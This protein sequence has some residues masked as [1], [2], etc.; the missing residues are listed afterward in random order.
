MFG[1]AGDSITVGNEAGVTS[2]LTELIAGSGDEVLNGAGA[3]SGLAFFGSADGA[4]NDTLT[5]G[6]GN[7]TLVAGT[8]NETL[9]G[10]AGSDLFVLNMQTDANG[11]ITIADFAGSS[12]DV[13]GF[14]RWLHARRYRERHRGRPGSGR[15]LRHHAFRQHDGHLHGCF[16]RE[17][18]QRSH[19]HVLIRSFDH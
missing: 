11:N 19:R 6:F 1:S 3:L 16:R 17:R 7:D 12:S 14:H 10:G 15:Q 2:G 18:P 13:I 8:G 4:A 9:T 5:G